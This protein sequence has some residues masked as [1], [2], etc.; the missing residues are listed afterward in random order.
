MERPPGTSQ[1]LVPVALPGGRSEPCTVTLRAQ[2][3][4]GVKA[5][6]AT[7]GRTHICGSPLPPSAAPPALPADLPQQVLQL[8]HRSNWH[9]YLKAERRYGC[10]SALRC[11]WDAQ[12]PLLL[13]LA[14]ADGLYQQASEG[15]GWD[16]GVGMGVGGRS[17]GVGVG[18]AGGGGF[19]GQQSCA[20]LPGI[21]HAAP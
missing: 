8:W 19:A 9:W 18:G 4:E 5:R 10:C 3:W 13:H 14:T 11:A 12:A 2:P 1:Q 6:H 17:G 20:P 15:E 16:S 21:P 7:P